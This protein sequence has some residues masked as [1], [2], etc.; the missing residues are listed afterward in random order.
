MRIEMPASIE[1]DIILAATCYYDVFR[2]VASAISG[3]STQR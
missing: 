1:T 2:R 3:V